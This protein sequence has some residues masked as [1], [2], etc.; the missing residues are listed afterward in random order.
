MTS[1]LDDPRLEAGTLYV[2]ATPIGNLEDLTLR[3]IR[4]LRD[5]DHVLAEDT[6]R[7]RALLTHLGIAGRSV[8]R[9]DAHASDG[10]RARVLAW[11]ERG[12]TVALVTDAGTPVVS[13]PGSRLIRLVWDSGRRVVPVPGPSA[14]T[15]ALSGTGLGGS[16][17]VFLGFP[18]RESPKQRTEFL[19]KVRTT[20]ETVVFFESPE[21]IQ[22]TLR[23]L[24]VIDPERF[25]VVSRELTKLHEQFL[26]GSIAEVTERVADLRGEL[27]VVLGPQLTKPVAQDQGRIQVEIEAGLA[28]KQA[29]KQI[30]KRISALFGLSGAEAY[31][32]VL[33]AKNRG[34]PSP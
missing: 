12:D 7:A 9:Y 31:D 30:A 33:E 11:L 26:R 18:P 6:R 34:E 23:E 14:I 3:A 19:D 2:V 4:T 25:C 10:D 29:A 24:G 5:A 15:A 17:F 13:D 20:S 21:R 8:E 22:A 27:T 32:R 28:K 16:G 1:T